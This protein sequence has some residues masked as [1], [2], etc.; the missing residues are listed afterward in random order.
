[1][2]VHLSLLFI[3]AWT[4]R[5]DLAA[6]KDA[7]N[8]HFSEVAD[9]DNHGSAWDAALN[10]KQG[11]S[12][13][14]GF[15]RNAAEDSADRYPNSPEIVAWGDGVV[16]RWA[17]ARI[18][19]NYNCNSP[20]PTPALGMC[21]PNAA[22]AN[23]LLGATAE[24]WAQVTLPGFYPAELVAIEFP[25]YSEGDT[26][27][28]LVRQI[29]ALA[30]DIAI[31]TSLSPGLM[32]YA[33]M[34]DGY[35]LGRYFELISESTSITGVWI[36]SETPPTYRSEIYSTSYAMIMTKTSMYVIVANFLCLI[37]GLLRLGDEI[38][39]MQL[40]KHIH[41]SIWKGYVDFWNVMDLITIT[42][43]IVTSILIMALSTSSASQLTALTVDGFTF[44]L[45]DYANLTTTNILLTTVF[46]TSI[47]TALLVCISIFKYFSATHPGLALFSATLW[48]ARRPLQDIILV[49]LYIIVFISMVVWLI[50]SWM[51]GNAE[52]I[53]FGGTFVSIINLCL[54]FYDFQ[55]FTGGREF[56]WTALVI[57]VTIIFVVCV[58]GLVI[59]SQNIILAIIA[60]AYSKVLDEL[61][62]SISTYPSYISFVVQTVW[63]AAVSSARL[64]STCFLDWRK[65][66][67]A[68]L[69]SAPN[70]D[71]KTMKLVVA[72]HGSV[73]MFPE[74]A[75]LLVSCAIAAGES[76][77]GGF[78]EEVDSHDMHHDDDDEEEASVGTGSSA[79]TRARLL[80]AVYSKRGLDRDELKSLLKAVVEEYKVDTLKLLGFIPVHRFSWPT[81][82]D[83]DGDEK[84]ERYLSCI[85]KAY[86]R[87]ISVQRLKAMAMADDDSDVGKSRSRS[88]S[89]PRLASSMIKAGWAGVRGNPE[90]EVTDL[91]EQALPRVV[92]RSD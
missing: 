41:G 66:G 19:L 86:G 40:A 22:A 25:I 5:P 85:M 16:L 51:G 35:N 54:G 39:D 33:I 8:A 36:N 61:A 75:T 91:E 83:P 3:A 1:M 74:T 78:G 2:C 57:F 64:L 79:E 21:A 7:L 90:L 20:P 10:Q 46:M 77:V 28:V 65:A 29:D 58:F 73:T 49:V 88:I 4:L 26:Q 84:L 11:V 72:R 63:F 6:P 43:T 71:R 9:D 60:D 56:A 32:I 42:L 37:M 70:K 27:E 15:Y 87:K 24:Q 92:S 47:I 67:E 34:E 55:E 13:L 44:T 52:F 82:D 80:A 68:T 81:A 12:H 18:D 62:L 59:I 69:K 50:F 30:A 17:V 45:S 14:L 48:R 38:H 53:T 89:R 23:A 31:L 76:Q